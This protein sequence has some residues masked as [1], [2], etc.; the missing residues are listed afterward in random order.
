MLIVEPAAAPSI[1]NGGIRR[2]VRMM[3]V[4]AATNDIFSSIATILSDARARESTIENERTRSP[5]TNIDITSA[6][7][8]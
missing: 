3:F 1:P 6:P 8:L 7:P 5:S 2:T 4:N